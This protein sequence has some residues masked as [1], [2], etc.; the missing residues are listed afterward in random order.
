MGAAVGLLLALTFLTIVAAGLALAVAAWQPRAIP[1][2]VITAGAA[3]A[4]AC[5]LL[6]VLHGLASLL[7]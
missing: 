3:V 1:G 6:A 4:V 7:T 2:P 5:F